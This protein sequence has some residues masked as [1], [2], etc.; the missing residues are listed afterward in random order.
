MDREHDQVLRM[1]MPYGTVFLVYQ[2]HLRN[3]AG[4]VLRGNVGY[5]SPTIAR[6]WLD[7]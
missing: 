4:G 6:L 2:P 7:R 3:M 5:G 1:W